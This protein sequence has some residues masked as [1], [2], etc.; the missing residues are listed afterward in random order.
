MKS[1]N[2]ND[3]RM[4]RSYNMSQ[5]RSKDTKIECNLPLNRTGYKVTIHVNIMEQLVCWK[6]SIGFQ[7]SNGL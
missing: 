6:P 2:Y 1:L 4:A 7:H 3:G 5:I